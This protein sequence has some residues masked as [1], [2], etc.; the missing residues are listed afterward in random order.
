MDIRV[1]RRTVGTTI[2]IDVSGELD[3]STVPHLHGELAAALADHPGERIVVDLDGVISLDDTA[4]GV[5]LGC[6]ARAREATGDLVVVC[7]ERR[8]RARLSVTRF[9]RAVDVAASM[10]QI[11]G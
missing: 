8:L 6:A 3:L 1:V 7:S 10:P 11:S 4:L 5:L 9:D 2:V